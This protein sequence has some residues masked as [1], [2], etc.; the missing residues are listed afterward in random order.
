MDK[1][2]LAHYFEL[3]SAMSSITSSPASIRVICEMRNAKTQD[4]KTAS[5]I[6]HRKTSIKRRVY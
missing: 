5:A 2:N 3:R 1:L 4:C 6:L